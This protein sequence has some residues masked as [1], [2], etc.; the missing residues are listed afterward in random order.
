[1]NASTFATSTMV[2][3]LDSSGALVY[4]ERSEGDFFVQ[5][6]KL[7]DPSYDA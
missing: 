6:N 3:R 4:P 2:Y 7:Q 5:R 1:M